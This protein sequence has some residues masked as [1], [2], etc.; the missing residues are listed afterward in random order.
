MA[1]TRPYLFYD[2][3]IS[4]CST[5][6]RKVEAK[7]VFQEGNVYLLKRCPQHGP[8][9]ILIADDIDYYRRCREVFIKPPEMPQVYN[10]AVKWGCPYDCGLC[11]DHEQ[12]SCL[13]LVEI[14]DYCNLRCPV[15]YAASGPERQQFRTLEQIEKMLDAVVRNEGHL[16]WCS[17]PAANR[18]CT[19][20]FLPSS[21]WQRRARSNI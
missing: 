1:K 6:Y 21:K 2:V 13:T 4:I 17:F 9:R 20:I 16:T 10:T 5:C 15:C 18:H 11:T 19:R 7:T 8:E 12:H 3:A 14:C